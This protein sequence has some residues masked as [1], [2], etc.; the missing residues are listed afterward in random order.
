MRL[1]NQDCYREALERWDEVRQRLKKSGWAG[2]DGEDC[3]S[4]QSS[5]G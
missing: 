2:I 5:E 4:S 1:L 3:V